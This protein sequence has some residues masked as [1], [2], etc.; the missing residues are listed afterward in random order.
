MRV[1]RPR[2]HNEEVVADV[3]IQVGVQAELDLR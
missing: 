2:Q 3:I 1:S